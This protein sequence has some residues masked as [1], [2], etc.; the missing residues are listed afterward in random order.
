MICLTHEQ[1]TLRDAIPA[2]PDDRITQI[3]RYK[4]DGLTH[5]QIAGHLS[6]SVSTINRLSSLIKRS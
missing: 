2:R 6:V 4:L 1:R 3:L 5:Q